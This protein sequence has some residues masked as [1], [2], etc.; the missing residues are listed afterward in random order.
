MYDFS[1]FDNFIS[2]TLGQ[3][4]GNGECWD[5]IN[6]LWNHLGGIYYTYPPSDPSATNHGV[7]WGWINTEARSANTITHLTQIP[8]LSDVKRG[9][10]V[11][12]SAGTYGHAGF[13]QTDYTGGEYLELYSQNFNHRYVTLDNNNM[14]T[15]VGAW[16]YDAWSQ[17]TPPPPTRT[18]T[19]FKWVLYAN[20]LRNKRNM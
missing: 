2:S 12:Y 4:I 19:H 10:V 7:K 11:V 6:L 15:F 5:Y 3:A 20:K 1:S 16:R 17:P 8:N 14:S 18:E 9:D 13:A